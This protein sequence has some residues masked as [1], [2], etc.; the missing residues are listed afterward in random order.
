[1]RSTLYE[2]LEIDA[3]SEVDV[4]RSAL[5]KVLRRF[6]SAPRDPSGDSEEAVR[7]VA[8]ASGILTDD[9][10][11][12]RYD[13]SARPAG[14]ALNPWRNDASRAFQNSPT[15]GDMGNLSQPS[16]GP[17]SVGLESQTNEPILLPDVPALADA[18]PNESLWSD[19]NVGLAFLLAGALLLY[20]LWDLL[21]MQFGA[22]TLIAA[23]LACMAAC[24]GGVMSLNKPAADSSATSLSRLAI[25]KWRRESSVFLGLPPPQQDTAWI[26]RLRMMELTRGAAGFL[27]QPC[28]G[29]RA[30]ARCADYALVSFLVLGVIAV[31]SAVFAP[32]TAMTALLRSVILLPLFVVLLTII[33]DALCIKFFRMT[34]GKWLVGAVVV[35]G[36]TQIVE[37]NPQTARARLAWRRAIAFARTAMVFGIWPLALFRTSSTLTS[38]LVD[39]GVWEGASDSVVVVRQTP[40]L[41]RA[42]A[43]V[44]S[45]AAAALLFS[46]WLSDS[47]PLAQLVASQFASTQQ[48]MMAA[49]TNDAKTPLADS[50]T[51]TLSQGGAT[52][53]SAPPA[54]APLIT[55]NRAKLSDVEVKD[56]P[57][58]VRN[59]DALIKGQLEAQARA[60]QERR[61]RIER[62]EEQVARVKQGGSYAALK[63][64]CQAWTED[65]PSS[66][67]AWR[68]LGLAR[69][70]SG[71]PR[72]ALPALRESLKIE[73]ND[74]EVEATILRILR[75]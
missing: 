55:I 8:L 66:A 32:S 44:L 9:A 35:L 28:I 64:S 33:L 67:A 36:V 22:L 29:L 60:A 6:W 24:V 20:G 43:L 58:P 40:L 65:Q 26:F 71:D 42:T 56:A 38:A 31:V 3:N 4:I 10:R 25:V 45:V 59:S 41:G 5:R 54:V 63:A 53:E 46:V 74:R 15:G 13:A 34:P 2:A 7:F 12:Q 70:Q 11:R 75:P 14:S 30:L 27:T 16:G 49:T 52:T 69:Y 68:C 47:K 62:V 51:P 57:A 73:P 21:G 1:M 50:A 17:L 48:A 61:A 18:L 19:R 23:W 72:G 39:E 37:P